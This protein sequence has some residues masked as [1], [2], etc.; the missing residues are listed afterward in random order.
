LSEP[1]SP[2]VDGGV[3]VE[4]ASEAGAVVD[5][6]VVAF[7]RKFKIFE[8]TLLDFVLLLVELSLAKAASSRARALQNT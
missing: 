5:V 7:F 3:V 2:V 6:I 4:F 1:S 8:S